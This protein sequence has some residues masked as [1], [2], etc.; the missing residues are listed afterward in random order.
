[1]TMIII[2]LLVVLPSQTPQST[3]V[4]HDNK[5]LNKKLK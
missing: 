2:L 1:M 5:H 3:Q 4:C